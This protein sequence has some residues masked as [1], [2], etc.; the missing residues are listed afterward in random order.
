MGREA[1]TGQLFIVSPYVELFSLLRLLAR[2]KDKSKDL[3][4]PKSAFSFNLLNFFCV[5][6]L[7][8]SLFS[9]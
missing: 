8:V 2:E 1:K 6:L 3:L 9:Y 5:I 7:L 4:W